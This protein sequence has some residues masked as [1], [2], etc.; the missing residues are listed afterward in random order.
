[1]HIEQNSVWKIRDLEGIK[2]GLYRVLFCSHIAEIVIIYP[3]IEKTSIKRPFLLSLE[4]FESSIKSNGIA[5]GNF[6]IPNYQ[7][8][9][10]ES[11]PEKY[12]EKRN[13]NFSLIKELGKVRIS[14]SYGKIPV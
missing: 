5:T 13:Y 9:N 2:S 1:M 6:D 8:F 4:L 11:L 7:L 14:P 10:D 12:L 3:L